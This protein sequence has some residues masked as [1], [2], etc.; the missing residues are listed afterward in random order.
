MYNEKIVNTYVGKY[1]HCKI[2]FLFQFKKYNEYKF[3]F[4]DCEKSIVLENIDL[5][6]HR[7]TEYILK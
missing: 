7:P 3:K 4:S 5:S 1:E 6:D 2:D